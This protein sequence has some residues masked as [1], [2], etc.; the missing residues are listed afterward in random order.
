ML[1]ISINVLNDNL[2]C[3][4]IEMVGGTKFKPI[5]RFKGEN[6]KID[7]FTEIVVFCPKCHDAF[8]V[9]SPLHR[10]SYRG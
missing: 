2:M 1:I 7:A 5:R 10:R 8:V 3:E 9:K 6:D 4:T